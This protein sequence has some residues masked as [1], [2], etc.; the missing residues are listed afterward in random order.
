MTA[1]PAHGYLH[2]PFCLRKCP[3]CDFPSRPGTAEEQAGYVEALLI[4]LAEQDHGRYQ[5]LY[6]GGGT[7]TILAL[8]VWD[9]LLRG[10]R[11]RI[12]L[13]AQ[14]EWTVEANPATDLAEVLPRL[15]AAG[16]NRLSLGCQ[17]FQAPGLAVLGRSHDAAQAQAA[18][19][20]ATRIFPQVNADLIIGWPGQTVADLLADLRILAQYDLDHVSVYHL[21]I[22]PDTGFARQG[23]PPIDEERSRELLLT[24]WEQLARLGWP[25]Y[26][27]SNFARPGHE[28]RHNLAGWRQ[29]DYQAAGAGAVSTVAGWRRRRL[30]DPADYLA[31]VHSGRT[32]MADSEELTADLVL[33]EAWML[34]LRL[35]EGVGE[36]RLQ[37]LGDDPARF[38]P[39]AD[40][41]AADGLLVRQAGR[42]RLTLAGRLVQDRVTVTLLP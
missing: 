14:A 30:P 9:R 24:A 22:E 10:V 32:P 34:G 18:L 35:V 33:A 40:R 29:A 19:T 28:C 6:I 16:V 21:G 26:E 4:E 17:S 27:T 23:L 15:A 20:L 37:A 41:L 5:T 11:A 2:I 13:A 3:Y 8:P 7:P 31:A 36:D 39:L 12:E 1:R 38:G 42:I 25:A